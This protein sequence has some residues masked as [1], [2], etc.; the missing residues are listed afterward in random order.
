VLIAGFGDVGQAV[1]NM[2]G[3]SAAAAAGSPVPFVAFDLTVDRVQAAQRAGFNVLYGDAAR[4]KVRRRRRP[5]CRVC[6]GGSRGGAAFCGV[7]G[8]Q[9]RER[10]PAGGW[11]AVPPGAR[12]V[13]PALR[14]QVLHAAGVGKP[15]AIAVCYT[16][17]QRAISAVGALREA[18]PDVPIYVRAVDLR[19]AAELDLAG[20]V[21]ARARVYGQGFAS[22]AA[23]G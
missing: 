7:P 23:R 18:Y 9:G 20:E 1:A 2:L 12:R 4:P 19:H 15:R 6:P 22:S 17:R 11:A 8:R 21:R 5:V 16:A 3:G 14:A 13:R 10:P